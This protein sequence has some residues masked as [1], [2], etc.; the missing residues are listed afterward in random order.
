[1]NEKEQERKNFATLIEEVEEKR[2]Q[3][4]AASQLLRAEI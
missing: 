4:S 1:M 2:K 3:S